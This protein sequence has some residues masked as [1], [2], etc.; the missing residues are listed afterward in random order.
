VCACGQVRDRLDRKAGVEALARLQVSA[1]RGRSLHHASLVLMA[2]TSPSPRRTGGAPAELDQFTTRRHTSHRTFRS[3]VVLPAQRHAARCFTFLAQG[4]GQRAA[5]AG[6]TGLR[7]L[8]RLPS[9]LASLAPLVFAVLI[10][11]R[12]CCAVR[13]F[14][15]LLLRTSLRPRWLRWVNRQ[16]STRRRSTLAAASSTGDRSRTRAFS[17]AKKKKKK[18]DYCCFALLWYNK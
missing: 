4:K 2:T 9:C 12:R 14:S 3:F 16:Q 1:H 17:R 11:F 10:F 5:V 13:S 7:C 15:F 18:K 8:F 6:E